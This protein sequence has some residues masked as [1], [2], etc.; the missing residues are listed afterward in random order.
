MVVA[1]WP[2]EQRGAGSGRIRR[3]AF[4]GALCAALVF[5]MPIVF[6]ILTI[7]DRGVGQGDGLIGIVALTGMLAIAIPLGAAVGTITVALQRRWF[8]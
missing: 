7:L 1:D 8:V 2:P 4:A 3:G 5:L 6:L